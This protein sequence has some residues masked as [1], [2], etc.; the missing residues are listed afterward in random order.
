MEL[1]TSLA[2]ARFAIS[3]NMKARAFNSVMHPLNES[4]AAKAL[5]MTRNPGQG[6]DLLGDN[7]DIEVKFNLRKKGYV[8]KSWRVLGHEVSWGKNGRLCFWGLGFYTLDREV[9]SI[10]SA[11]S[12]V[13]LEKKV[14]ERELFIVPWDWIDQY[15]AYHHKGETDTSKW[16]HYIIFPKYK[17]IPSTIFSY[18][19][20]KGIVHLTEGVD[21][22]LL[23]QRT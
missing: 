8:H 4:W 17:D 23:I 5:G 14:L 18:P 1:S 9:K 6:I 3:V 10:K 7:C 13:E 15:P 2:P 19:V 11:I 20:K 22:G 12:Q 21:K 16:D